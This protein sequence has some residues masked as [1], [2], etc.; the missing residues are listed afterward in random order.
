M[1]FKVGDVVL[2]KT[3]GPEM[4]VEAADEKRS[5]VVCAWVVDNVRQHARFKSL[6]LRKVVAKIS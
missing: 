4:T 5:D 1:G 6:A 3:G 2:L